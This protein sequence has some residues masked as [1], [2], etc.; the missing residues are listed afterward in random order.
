MDIKPRPLV[1]VVLAVRNEERHVETVLKSL[2]QQETYNCELEILIVDGDS[3]D[4]T[5]EIVNR[6]SSEDP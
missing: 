3:S 4:A 2:L 1:S 6:I 5:R